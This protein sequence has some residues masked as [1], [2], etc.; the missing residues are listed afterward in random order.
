[1]KTFVR[2]AIFATFM[3]GSLLWIQ[4]ASAQAADPLLGT[5]KLDVAESKFSPGPPPKSI[6]VTFE[7]AGEGVKVTADAVGADGKAT[8]TTYTGNYDGK[9]Y[10]V[11]G[12]GT[13]ADTVSLKRVDARTTERTDK[14]GGKV[15]MTF[16]RTVSSDGKLLTVTIKGTNR[17]GQTVNDVVM[18][19]KQ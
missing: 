8:H 6:T 16:T 19:A 5:W 4:S 15:V 18:L 7:Q 13:G 2:Q 12:S 11:T 17:K 1:M 14:K 3:V 10:P 9:D